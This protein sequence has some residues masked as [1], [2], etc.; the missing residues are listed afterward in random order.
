MAS[1]GA[2]TDAEV[3]AQIQ[4]MVS[5]IKAEALE[6]A[7][8]IRTAAEEEFAVAKD[9]VVEA[10][11]ARI[12]KEFKRREDTM[13]VKAKIEKS[14]QQNA[15]RIDVLASRDQLVRDVLATAR[16]RLG[17]VSDPSS[18]TYAQTLKHLVLDGV[19]KLLVPN[20]VVQLVVRCRACDVTPARSAVSNA[21]QTLGESQVR[22][23]L[24]ESTPLPP[25]P[26]AADADDDDEEDG[27][28]KSTACRGGVVVSTADGKVIVDN[29]LDA[30][31]RLCFQG[32]LP[33]VRSLLFSQ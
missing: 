1:G 22:L 3:S 20:S 24:D 19:K 10:E 25:P 11:R 32:A 6:K 15:Q 7:D 30:R 18:A 4:Q 2:L 26:T 16:R 27:V 33:Q 9:Q 12:L 5:F 14:A 21:Q 17:E 13:L 8:E 28:D 29:T 31:L 23:T